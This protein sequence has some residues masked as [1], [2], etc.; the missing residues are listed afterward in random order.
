MTKEITSS[1]PS[2]KNNFHFTDEEFTELKKIYP[3][4]TTDDLSI[5]YGLSIHQI[6]R[7]GERLR[8]KK[9]KNCLIKKNKQKKGKRDTTVIESSEVKRS[10]SWVEK[11]FNPIY[12]YP[13]VERSKNPPLWWTNENL[14]VNN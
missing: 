10:P 8:L 2:P 11:L 5:K 9:V 3:I 4:T 6:N 7:W 13:M 1:K 12:S 14:K